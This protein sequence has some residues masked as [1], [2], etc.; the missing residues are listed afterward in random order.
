ML[1][2]SRGACNRRSTKQTDAGKSSLSIITPTQIF[3]KSGSI[4][5]GL[6]TKG[7]NLKAYIEP[8]K[9][10]MAADPVIKY[11]NREAL[12]KAIEKTRKSMEKAASELE[13]IEA[14]R[15]R[16]ELTELQNLLRSKS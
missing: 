7:I 15:Y 3:K 11:M 1:T 2:R 16:D 10:D 8:E 13:F 9:I 12:E 4:F 5:K 6:S 14:A